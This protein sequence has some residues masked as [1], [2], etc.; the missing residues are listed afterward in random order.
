MGIACGQ[1]SAC[2]KFILSM[3]AHARMIACTNVRARAHAHTHTHTHTH[4]HILIPFE[5]REPAGLKVDIA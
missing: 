4:T 2:F 1:V 3:H 5:D